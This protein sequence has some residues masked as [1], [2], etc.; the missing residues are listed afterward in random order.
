V[1]PELFSLTIGIQIILSS[2]LLSVLGMKHEG[3]SRKMPST[4]VVSE[5]HKHLVLNRR[6]TVLAEHLAGSIPSRARVLD[7]GCGDGIIDHLIQQA[8]P[9]VTIQGIDVLVRRLRVLVIQTALSFSALLAV[10]WF[11]P[12]LCRAGDGNCICPRHAG[13]APSTTLAPRKPSVSGLAFR[14]Y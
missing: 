11:H 9:D 10:V 6:A 8:R 3:S 5:I 12:L 4:S 7:I 2:F 14:E 13:N 1:I